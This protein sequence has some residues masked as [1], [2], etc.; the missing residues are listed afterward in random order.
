MNTD[1]RYIF[2][3]LGGTFRVIREDSD[4]L[5]AAKTKIMELCGVQEAD[6]CA[7]FDAVIDKRYDQYRAWALKFMC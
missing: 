5:A 1:I 2:L 3:D 7:W 6:P 4:Y